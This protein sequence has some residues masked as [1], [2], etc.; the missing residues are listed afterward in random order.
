M[1]VQVLDVQ[2]LVPAHLLGNSDPFVVCHVFWDGAKIGETEM[3]WMSPSQVAQ[4]GGQHV[5]GQDRAARAPRPRRRALR[6][7][8]YHVHKRGIGYFLGRPSF[9]DQARQSTGARDER[10]LRSGAA[11]AKK[12]RAVKRCGSGS[13]G[14]VGAQARLCSSSSTERWPYRPPI[15][16]A[17]HHAGLIRKRREI[18]V[19]RYGARTQM[20]RSRRPPS[21]HAYATRA[22][23]VGEPR[24]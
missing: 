18:Y 16:P 15:P 10:K 6:I 22:A 23:L 14:P 19:P 13:A 9:V 1:K 21:R 12:P 17:P 4:P 5:L 8:V 3:V 20:P 24:T 11:Q 2:D 7:E